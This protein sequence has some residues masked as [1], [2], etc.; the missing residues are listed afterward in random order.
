MRQKKRGEYCAQMPLYKLYEKIELKTL[1][2]SN[3]SN[4]Q[5]SY[6]LHLSVVLTIL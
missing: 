3:S 1:I 4:P 2:I 6:F 5:C